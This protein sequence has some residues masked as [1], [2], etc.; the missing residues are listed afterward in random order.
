MAEAEKFVADL[1]EEIF[2]LYR[3]ANLAYWEHSL[4]GSEQAGRDLKEKML[5]LKRI[6]EDPKRFQRV[7]ELRANSRAD[8]RTHRCLTLIDYA[9][10]A[11]QGDRALKE[12]IVEL[13]VEISAVFG[14]HR[15]EISGKQVSD[16]EIEMILR[17]ERDEEKRREAWYAS[18]EVGF[19]TVPILRDLVRLRNEIA[20]SAGYRN[21]YEM[22]MALQEIDSNWLIHTWEQLEQKTR[23]GYRALMEDLK[24]ATADYLG[25]PVETLRPWDVSDPFYQRVPPWFGEEASGA[26]EVDVVEVARKTY[27]DLGMPVDEILGRSDLYEKEGKNPHAYCIDI[28]RSGDIRV[29]ANCVNDERWANTML[30][31]LG[32]AVYD[33]YISRDLPFTLRTPAHI[34]STEAIAILMGRLSR[35]P[36][37][38]KHYLK[39]QPQDTEGANRFRR[40][41]SLIFLRWVLVMTF[42]EKALY[43]EPERN[44]EELWWD[45]VERVQG[46]RRPHPLPG[47]SWATKIHLAKSPVYYHNYL[48]GEIMSWQMEDFILKSTNRA[49]VVGNAAGLAL[50]KN[51]LFRW[52]ALRTWAD[53]LKH[54]VGA[55]FNL[56]PYLKVIGA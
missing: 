7:R 25:R 9:F 48:L 4:T 35:D 55:G 49:T 17:T 54:A 41:E 1:E 28:D 33:Q 44:L 31:E 19:K 56:E 13:E 20:R 16:N 2:P 11:N 14:N 47:Y 5:A 26:L 34:A 15:P 53:S 50:L 46:I 40:A 27:E 45:F 8:E 42:F 6:Y 52:G 43:E 36:D 22:M 30:H 29:L 12:R 10:T 3:A 21:Y 23:A 39:L 24:A 18:K 37:W 38:R 32:H 51:G